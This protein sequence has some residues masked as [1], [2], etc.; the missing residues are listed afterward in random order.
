MDRVLVCKE[1]AA[2]SGSLDEICRHQ[3]RFIPKWEK[4]DL[5]KE[6]IRLITLS[7]E[8]EKRQKSI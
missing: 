3:A 2:K 8:E 6:I 1:C 7:A 4:E 5:H